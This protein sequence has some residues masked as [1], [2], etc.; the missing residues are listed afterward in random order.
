MIGL[1]LLLIVFAWSRPESVMVE[2]RYPV[3]MREG[4][5]EPHLRCLRQAQRG[6]HQMFARG[7]DYLMCNPVRSG[8]ACGGCPSDEC[9]TFSRSSR[10]Q[11]VIWI[12][13]PGI[14]MVRQRLAEWW[15]RCANGFGTL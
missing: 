14:W 4:I 6:V 11:I 2:V 9:V 13:S 1:L 12:T 8:I 10:V 3:L 7:S 15:S 5:R